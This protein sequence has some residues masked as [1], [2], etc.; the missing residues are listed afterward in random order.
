MPMVMMQGTDQPCDGVREGSVSLG[1]AMPS[2]IRGPAAR[3]P[4][5]YNPAMRY[6]RDLSVLTMQA[7][8]DLDMIPGKGYI[9]VLDGLCGT[10]IRSM[11]F[12]KEVDWK[13]RTVMFHACDG[14]PLAVSAGEAAAVENGVQMEFFAS[15]LSRH[16]ESDR[17]SYIDIDPFGSPVPFLV[18]ALDSII[19]GGIIAVTATDT[20]ALCGSVPRVTL[21]RYGSR[22]V[23]TEYLKEVSCRVLMGWMARTAASLEMALEPVLFYASDHFVRGMV[24]VR[25]GA[26][27]SDEMLRSMGFVERSAPR[28]PIPV[29]QCRGGDPECLGPLWLGSLEDPDVVRAM[30][31]RSGDDHGPWAYVGDRKAVSKMLNLA[32]AEHG[33]PPFGYDTDRIASFL[34]TNPLASAKV[35]SSLEERGI[36]GSR[37]RFGDKIIRTEAGWDIMEGIFLQGV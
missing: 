29:Q 27:R 28:M 5:F 12:A 16:L 22:M 9:K 10:G 19:P 6:N 14:N 33:M 8:H 15:D 23:K 37:S 21:R 31:A 30:I 34:R 35:L 25:R 26:K 32:M 2:R 1:V 13:G 24:K 17:Y 4:V 36:P 11:R 18:H 3:S 20:A 7:L